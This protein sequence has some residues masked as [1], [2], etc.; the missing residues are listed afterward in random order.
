MLHCAV[1]RED[2]LV[3][4]DFSAK[5]PT[6]GSWHAAQQGS[7]P[8]ACRPLT[9]L[10]PEVGAQGEFRESR[11]IPKAFDTA[12]AHSPLMLVC[13]SS[14]SLSREAVLQ[15]WQL[16]QRP[17]ALEQSPA[18]MGI[19]AMALVIFLGVQNSLPDYNHSQ[20]LVGDMGHN[21]V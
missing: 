10:L 20:S 2:S 4:Q 1:R 6:L 3:S 7:G 21:L 17:S 15:C 18:Q 14:R 8:W 16:S 12:L 9:V 19:R 5:V 11:N 13:T